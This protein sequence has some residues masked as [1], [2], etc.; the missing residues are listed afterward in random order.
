MREAFRSVN[1][2]L[3]FL[4][5]RMHVVVQSLSCVQIFVTHG[6]QHTS[7]PCPSV[8]PG[9]CSNSCS[10]SQWRHPTISSS[11]AFFSCPPCFPTSGS[12]PV[13]QFFTLGGQSIRASASASVPPVNSQGWFSL[14]LTRLISFLSNGLLRV[15]SSTTVQKQVDS[16]WTA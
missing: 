13:S 16:Y 7:P 1:S 14:G 9:L 4:N 12:F 10:L 6:L 3:P 11:V 15:F 5:T 8:S 2:N